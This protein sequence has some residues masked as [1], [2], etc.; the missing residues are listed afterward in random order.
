MGALTNWTYRTFWANAVHPYRLLERRLQELAKPGLAIL[1]AGCGHSAPNLQLLRASGAT[2]YGVDLVPLTAQEGMDLLVAD[3]A[4]IPLPDASLDLIYSRSV[5]EHLTDPQIVYAEAARLL[6]PGG[7]WIFLTANRWDYVSLFSRLIPNRFHAAIVRR[8]E[9]RQE[10]DVFPTA[11]RTND[12]GQ[13]ARHAAAHGFAID[14]FE[15][16]GQYPAM[17]YRVDPLFLLATLYEKLVINCRM[18]AGLRGW[19]Y[20]ELVKE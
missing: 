5:M 14:R 11:Y 4:E 13:I 1:D 8:F 6:K 9:G 18:L 15:R 3:L 19:L 2:L 10:F 16:Y 17:F 20:V 7:R 12:R